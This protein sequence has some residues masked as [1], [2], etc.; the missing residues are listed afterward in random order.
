MLGEV[1]RDTADRIGRFQ[2]EIDA[3]AAVEINAVAADAAGQ[4][5]WVADRA[6]IRTV[7][8]EKIALLLACQQEQ[9]SS[10]RRNSGAR[11]G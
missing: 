3:A 10:S 4:E 7:I 11:G 5:L 8:A 9:V 2:I 6:G 1:A